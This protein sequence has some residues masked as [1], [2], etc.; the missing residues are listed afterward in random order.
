MTELDPG[1]T[2][3]NWSV[4]ELTQKG[5]MHSAVAFTPHD[6]IHIIEPKAS[7]TSTYPYK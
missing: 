2:L 7:Q 5:R 6:L 4:H 1:D 3:V